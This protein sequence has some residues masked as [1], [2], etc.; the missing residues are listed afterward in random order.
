MSNKEKPLPKPPSTPFGKKRSFD[1]NEK[2]EPLM[3]DHMAMAMAEGKLEEFLKSNIP[4]SEHARKLAEMMMGMTGMMPTGGFS[5]N[6][7]PK[8]EEFSKEPAPEEH[9][10]RSSDIQPPEDI[11]NAVQAGDLQGLMGLLA[12]E[13]AKRTGSSITDTSHEEKNS[14]EPSSAEPAVDKEVIDLLMKIA[15]DNDLSLDWL[16]FRALKRYV[17]EYRKSGNL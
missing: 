1:E 9:G 3:A 7:A 12:K 15:S 17:E 6:P 10:E 8:T 14:I 2:K 5:G 11:V 16:F 13:H 4:D